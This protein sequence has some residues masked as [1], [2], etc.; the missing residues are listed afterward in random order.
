[1]KF[2]VITHIERG[3]RRGNWL[4][5]CEISHPRYG[6]AAYEWRYPRGIPESK[7][8]ANAKRHIKYEIEQARRNGRI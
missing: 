3:M 6:H 1:M 4:Y 7:V 8:R 5:Y 2:K